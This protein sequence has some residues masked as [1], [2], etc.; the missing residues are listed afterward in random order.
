VSRDSLRALEWLEL[1]RPGKKE[2]GRPE[3]FEDVAC[4]GVNTER[5][6]RRSR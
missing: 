6:V 3:D 1:V 2:P 4:L 5:S